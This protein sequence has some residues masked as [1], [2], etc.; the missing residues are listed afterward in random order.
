M[1]QNRFKTIRNIIIA[2]ICIIFL[3]VFSLAY[4]FAV[5]P[6]YQDISDKTKIA[7]ASKILNINII[8]SINQKTPRN[9][10]IAFTYATL[11]SWCGWF[12]EIPL[13]VSC[14]SPSPTSKLSETE[15]AELLLKALKLSF[16]L[17]DTPFSLEDIPDKTHG[18]TC[19]IK[20]G[21]GKKVTNFFLAKR[22]D[23]LWYFT[24]EN[25][26]N[27]ETVKKFQ[28]YNTRFHFLDSKSRK[29]TS[30]IAC[31][32]YFTLGTLKLA[33]LNDD[34]SREILDLSWVNPIIRKKY[35]DALV[36]ILHKVME[37]EKVNI[38]SIPIKPEETEL[39]VILCASKQSGLS[40]YLQKKYLDKTRKK[41]TWVF[42]RQVQA[43]ALDIYINEKMIVDPK[44]DPLWFLLQHK[45]LNIYLNNHYFQMAIFIIL[46][47]L[48]STI[49]CYV[50]HKIIS[51][52]LYSILN[53]F[54]PSTIISHYKKYAKRLSKAAGI[55]IA[56]YLFESINFYNIIF[57]YQLLII[58]TYIIT[59]L[60][61]VISIWFTCELINLVSTVISFALKNSSIERFRTSFVIEI[62]RRL[63][64]ILVVVVFIGFLFQKLGINMS[65]FLTALGIGGIAIAY[66]G[67][68]TIENI[69]GS[70]IIAL[71]QPFKIGDWIIVGNIE[72]TVEHV[73]LRSTR[74]RT[75]KDSYITVPNVQFITSYVNNMNERNYRRY[76][77]TLEVDE[78]TSTE[79][80]Q[81]F[82]HGIEKIIINT[83]SI[84]QNEYH[85]KLN[86]LGQFSI[87]IMIYVF[88]IAPDWET[89]LRER[90][91]FI[92]NI[93]KLANEQNIKIS[94]YPKQTL[95]LNKD[96][97]NETIKE[98]TIE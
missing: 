19:N 72:G 22:N 26:T 62:I 2:L 5:Q 65:N 11:Y 75:F 80:L 58:F 85:I 96:N 98:N 50:I 87:K 31:Y 17:T 23:G 14:V 83:P 55:L 29:Y 18:N 79:L 91:I 73:G 88:F 7:D 25:F 71:E 89:E 33:G 61:C 27:T 94:Y 53:F 36:F 24:E 54:N 34:T 49:V 39:A 45:L 37:K 74:I 69:F 21:F 66:A 32:I 38:F 28:K 46:V 41:S 51:K 90:E 47:L 93:L 8:D 52:L 81:K 57:Y 44:E 4:Y 59:I 20:L 92:L 43:N 82:T 48:G 95:Y 30:P 56:L 76:F 63:L 10:F 15:K 1:K 13:A 3:G 60:F 97:H 78:S 86:D 42:N 64:S 70:I 12:K 40:I 6:L 68:D 67:K 16:L 9:L 84:R 77:T 35:G